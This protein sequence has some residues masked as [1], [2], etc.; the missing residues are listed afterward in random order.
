MNV[1]ETD[2]AKGIRERQMEK[3]GNTDPKYEETQTHT[4]ITQVL[5]GASIVFFQYNV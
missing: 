5:S 2:R 3:K 1:R 4:T